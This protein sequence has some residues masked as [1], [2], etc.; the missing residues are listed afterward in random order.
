[1][2]IARIVEKV[3]N[4]PFANVVRQKVFEPLDMN[5]SLFNNDVTTIIRNR[6]NAYLPRS[7]AVLA[8]L[9]KG[10]GVN[11]DAGANSS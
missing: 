9:A 5:S 6:A 2:L 10:A 11:A 3:Y 4:Q 7:E 8:E 1:M